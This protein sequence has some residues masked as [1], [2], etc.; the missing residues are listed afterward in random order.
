MEPMYLGQAVKSRENRVS[1]TIP[2]SAPRVI[3]GTSDQTA[4]S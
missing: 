2:Y 4:V 3:R 1:V